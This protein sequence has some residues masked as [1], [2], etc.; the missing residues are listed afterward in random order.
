MEWA[1]DISCILATASSNFNMHRR[2]RKGQSGRGRG[3]EAY[4]RSAAGFG[5]CLAERASSAPWRGRRQPPAGS[6]TAGMDGFDTR[7]PSSGT[8]PTPADPLLG[9]ESATWLL[10]AQLA[11]HK[12]KLYKRVTPRLPSCR[13]GCRGHSRIDNDGKPL[14]DGSVLDA[15]RTACSHHR[16]Q[17]TVRE[18]RPRG[19]KVD[20]PKVD[21]MKRLLSLSTRK[22]G[23]PDA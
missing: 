8:G 12:N 13:P 1:T 3:S 7:A 20:V 22:R 18:G 19:P 4:T 5:H 6:R 23:R 15:A 21:L 16:S 11:I 14:V 10:R 9:L 2:T 17:D